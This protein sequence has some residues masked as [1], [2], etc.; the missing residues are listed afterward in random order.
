MN[1]ARRGK[2]KKLLMVTPLVILLCFTFGCQDKEAMA[3]LEAFRAQAEVEEQ[4]KALVMRFSEAFVNGDI[5]AI[6]EIVSPD[7]VLHVSG[8]DKSLEN[9]IET[10]KRQIVMF[11]DRTGSAEEI[12][13]KGDKVILRYVFRATHGK[14][15]EGF[16]ATGNKIEADGIEIIRVENGKIVESWELFDSMSFALQVGMELKPKEGKK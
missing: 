3:E 9:T 11:P 16:P 1:P 15:F 7:F 2:M 14:D 4:N 6:K 5:E 13:A 12:I 8:K 10:L